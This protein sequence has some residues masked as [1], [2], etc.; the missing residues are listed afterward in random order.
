MLPSQRQQQILAYLAE[1]DC[2]TVTEALVR[3]GASPATLRRDFNELG[4]AGLVERVHGGI[5][6]LGFAADH[7]LPFSLR[8]QWYAEEKQRLARAAV[9]LLPENGVVFVD[10]GTTT[11]C[12]GEYLNAPRMTVI[13]NSLPLCNLLATRFP[14]E[15]GPN[16][17]LT[18]G[19]LHLKSGLLLGPNA[20]RSVTEY[21]AEIAVLSVRAMDGEALYNDN[22]Q[23]AGIE[24]VMIDHADRVMVIA[25]HS[26]MGQTSMCRICGLDRVD[27]IVTA[28]VP[29][30]R[31][32]LS[33]YR[34]AGV[35]VITVPME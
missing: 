1:H 15:G 13:T 29:E 17:Y 28:A 33:D 3:F 26:K 32:L 10:G 16:V 30:N 2:L 8:E 31:A 9:P 6:K 25:D 19:A 22:E 21:H 20:E 11:S 34:A 24:R 35:E 23:I 12:L 14:G 27:V 7:V 5:H 4:E 18:G